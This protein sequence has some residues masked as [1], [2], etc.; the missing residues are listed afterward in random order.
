MITNLWD[1]KCYGVQRLIQEFANTSQT[2]LIAYVWHCCCGGTDSKTVT[3]VFVYQKNC[4]TH[5]NKIRFICTVFDELYISQYS[6]HAWCSRWCC[7]KSALC[8]YK[9]MKCDLSLSQDSVCT[10]FRWG[11]SPYDLYC[12]GG[13]LSLTQSQ[14]RWGRHFKKYICKKFLSV[15]NS[16]KIIKKINPDFPKLWSQMYCHLFM[17][18]RV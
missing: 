2:M 16:A 8:I 4:S 12:V 18:H 5:Q 3:K 13:T 7:S 15:Y 6:H 1:S 14:F 17:V 10:V 11:P 9:S